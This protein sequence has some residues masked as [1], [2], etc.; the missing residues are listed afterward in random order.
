MTQ[1]ITIRRPDDWH[2]HLRDGDILNEVASFTVKHF[3][4]AIVMPNLV[5]PVTN[6]RLANEYRQRIVEAANDQRF[7]PL[8]TIYLTDNTDPS[9]VREAFEAGDIT[10]AKMYPAGATTNA[11]AGVTDVKKIYPLIDVMQSIGM[12]LLI[13]GEVVGHEYDVFD[14]EKIFVDTI[15]SAMHDAFP[16]QKIVLEH[17]TTA[18]GVDF[19]KGASKLVAATITPHH[20]MVNRTTMFQGGIRPHLYCLPI[21]KRREHQLALRKA[22]TSPSTKFFLGTDSA[23]HAEGDKQSACGC[24]GIFNAGTAMACYAQ[25]FDEENALEHLE[26]FASLNGPAFYGMPPND[27][28]ITLRKLDAPVATP[29]PVGSERIHQFLPDTPVHWQVVD[30][31]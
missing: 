4:R 19:V 29:A 15:L 23:P 25:V 12:P 17:V 13:H 18:D 3:S 20:L 24:A 11:D 1:E 30:A 21:A 27:D 10:A 16:E 26:R 22:A 28:F 9:E 5:P 14:R 31:S 8:M 6:G 7:T 2:L